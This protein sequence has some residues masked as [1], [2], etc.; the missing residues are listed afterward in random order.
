MFPTPI[1][2]ASPFVR[3]GYQVLLPIALVL[4][5]LAMAGY[6]GWLA[7]K[8]RPRQNA[9]IKQ[10]PQQSPTQALAIEH[11]FAAGFGL[12]GQ[13]HAVNKPAR[14]LKIQIGGNA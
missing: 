12:P 10:N 14:W 7:R 13:Q 3:T 2:K 6:Y 11:W 4:L 9:F 8:S 1:Q 5:L